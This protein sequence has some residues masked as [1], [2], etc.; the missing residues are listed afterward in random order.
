MRGE[1]GA[2]PE[3]ELQFSTA[4]PPD[5]AKRGRVRSGI[6]P[7]TPW[8]QLV[9]LRGGD[10]QADAALGSVCELYWKP[11]CQHIRRKGFDDHDAQDLT[12]EFMSKLITRGDFARIE[13]SRGRLR[14]YLLTALNHF[15]A[16]VYRDRAAEKRGGG[17]QTLSLDHEPDDEATPRL[18]PTSDAEGPD[19]QFD[20]AWATALLERV[21]EDLRSDFAAQGKSAVFEALQPALAW[22]GAGQDLATIGASIGMDAG[23]VRVAVHRMRL[24]YRNTL[25]RH[26][27]ATVET[28][29]QVEEEIRDLMAILRGV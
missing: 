28:E 1:R 22:N 20:R 14:S 23:A 4:M 12:Q 15:V 16:N 3:S 17:V 9:K 24:R 13:E 19:A 25:Y 6:L 21:L 8:T 18:D 10:A 7:A 26:I 27:A 2:M 11:I 5:A 29:E